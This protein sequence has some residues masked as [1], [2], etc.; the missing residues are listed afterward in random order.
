M[1]EYCAFFGCV[2][3]NR[4]PGIEASIRKTLPA[5][6]IKLVDVPEF[7]CCPAPGIFQSFNYKTWLTLA[8]RN[9]AVAE[10]HELKILTF[11]NGCFGSLYDANAALKADKKLR[12]EING[13]L[14]KIG[15]QVSGNEVVEHIAL[16]LYDKI[17]VK[18]IKE[19]VKKPLGL[20][21]A[22]HSG[23]H[24]LRSEPYK[25][26]DNNEKPR[27]LDDLVEALG[28]KSVKYD[29]KV[30]CCGA[31]GGVRTALAQIS[32]QIL[33]EKVKPLNSSVDC[34]TDLCPFCHLQLDKGQVELNTQYGLE[35]KFPVL[36][37]LQLLGLAMGFS[38]Q[39]LGITANFTPTDS[40]LKKISED[41][42][43]AP[44]IVP[45]L[46]KK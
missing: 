18:K 25:V 24:L 20:N 22:T 7:S 19:V 32:L 42:V 3:P 45:N 29:S 38:P 28:C 5:L 39:E 40:V 13:Y 35:Y 46:P 11:C 6:G 4:Y 17:G 9:L 43:V 37:Y 26:L 30:Q 23:C 33:H 16:F 34:L 41:Q 15:K 27:I 2:I 31:G 8:A 36:Y 10:E 1:Q 44:Q 21:V 14:G 12:A